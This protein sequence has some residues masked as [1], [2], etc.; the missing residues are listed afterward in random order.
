MIND[1]IV[2]TVVECDMHT[3]RIGIDAPS[4]VKIY[5]EEIYQEIKKANCASHNISTNL[6]DTLNKLVKYSDNNK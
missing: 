6:L 2:L 5:R 4:G 3:V 1:N